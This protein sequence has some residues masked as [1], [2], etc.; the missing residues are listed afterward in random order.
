[1]SPS[2]FTLTTQAE[3]SVIRPEPEYARGEGPVG[4]SRH[5]RVGSRK[6]ERFKK[7]KDERKR[8]G[9]LSPLER[10]KG[11]K[12]GS[13]SRRARLGNSDGCREIDSGRVGWIEQTL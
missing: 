8:S 4:D 7:R 2:L 10:G 9:R 12:I 1:M 13:G 5:G 11:R 3:A 6:S